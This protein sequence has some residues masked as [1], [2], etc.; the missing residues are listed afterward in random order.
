MAVS[1][2]T[3]Y[4][5]YTANGT[6]TSFALEFDCDNQ[7]HLIVL[8]DDVEPVVG[9][10]SLNGGAVI[11]GTAPEDGKKITIQ[12]NTPFSRNTDYQSYNNSFRPPAVN[13]DFDWIWLKLQEL[14]VADWILSNRI[15]DLRTYVDKQDNVLQDNIDSL[16][17]YVDDKDDELRNYLLNAIQ[18]QGVALDQLEE[19]YS[20]LM[21][22]LAQVAINRGWA[23]S[24]IVSA[25]GS[26]QQEINDFGGAKWW[27]KPLGYG[28]GAT[29]KLENGDIVKSTVAN[30]I[31]DPNE[32]EVI[33]PNTYGWFN[34]TLASKNLYETQA[35]LLDFIPIQYHAE[36]FA[37]TS[38]RDFSSYINYATN[39]IRGDLI[40]PRGVITSAEPLLLNRGV[41][42]LGNGP[43]DTI[44]RGSSTI[45]LL[46]GANC[47]LIQ[48]PRAQGGE[49]THYM[50]LENI[51]LDG[52]AAEQTE[53]ANLV[54][55][56]G[57]WVGSWIRN[58]FII[59]AYGTALDLDKG[60]DINI[61]HLWINSTISGDERYAFNSNSSYVGTETKQGMLNG[62][63]IYVENTAIERYTTETSPR[64]TP[65]NRGNAIN[66]QRFTSVNLNEVHLEGCRRMIDIDLGQTH[67][68]GKVSAA[69]VGLA[70][71]ADQA[72]VRL[73]SSGISSVHVGT[74]VV[75]TNGDGDIY[76]VK[77]ATGVTTSYPDAA[78]SGSP[79][80]MIGYDFKAGANPIVKQSSAFVGS[81]DAIK[82]G[83]ALPKLKLHNSNDLSI[84]SNDYSGMRS[85]SNGAEFYTTRNQGGTEKVFFS[86]NATANPLG[87]TV[88][89][90][91]PILLGVRSLSNNLPAGVLIRYQNATLGDSVA[92]SLSTGTASHLATVLTNTTAPTSTPNHI[93]QIFVDR[94]SKKC[95]LATGI[96]S[97]ADWT[98]LN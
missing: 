50:A 82:S 6:T 32:I 62:N 4:I 18:E 57:A 48:T 59:N 69:H 33:K 7:D 24:F 88:D 92:Y 81:V 70:S 26:T 98:L 93:G 44:A 13:K 28:V 97:A 68:F 31:V 34:E 67:R 75:T 36:I 58:L 14:G 35:R 46:A 61:H 86:I 25:D 85:S 90:Y 3:P 55:F 11:F 43:F 15:N 76:G 5:E 47:P 22:Q 8:V 27:D 42:F 19:Y 65:S 78:L 12:R 77:K 38:T 51:R 74:A 60:A 30:N 84:T 1:E 96:A 20:Y 52:N 29:V 49:S 53:F 79:A 39:E 87:N 2:Q 17:N 23:A 16:K 94:T 9:A 63:H 41:R 37:G 71:L 73:K 66:L 45:K 56:H 10:W 72:I 83:S 91:E 54:E 89:F 40:L 95:Y 21:Q 80:T 64:T